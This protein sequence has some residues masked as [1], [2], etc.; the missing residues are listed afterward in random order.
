MWARLTAAL[1]NGFCLA[2]LLSDTVQ[3]QPQDMVRAHDALK[4]TGKY[5]MVCGVI[6]SA[7]YLRNVRGGPTHLNFDKP[8][9]KHD[10]SA[11]IF[12][13]NC[14]HF[15]LK[16]ETLGGYKA[17]VYGK[18]KVYKGKAQ[19]VLVKSSQLSVKAPKN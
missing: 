18:I 12:E 11:I 10:F 13:K 9:P 3:A 4:L 17:C 7:N 1:S 2:L 14:K 8:Y 15:K 5:T 19:I 6:A 16:P